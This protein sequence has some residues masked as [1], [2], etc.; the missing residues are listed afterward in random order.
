MKTL[1][2]IYFSLFVASVCFGQNSPQPDSKIEIGPNFEKELFKFQGRIAWIKIPK[3]PAA[4]KPWVWRAHFPDWHTQIDSIL[5]N[6]GFHIAYVNTNDMFGSPAAMQVWDNFYTFLLKNRSFAP[7]VALE[8]VS[9][10]G[11]Y[12]YNWAKRNPMKVSCIY[13]EAPVCDFKSCPLKHGEKSDWEALLKAYKFTHEQALAHTDN[14]I[15]NLKGLAACKVPIMHTVSLEDQIVPNE[16]NSFVLINQYIR[17]GGKATIW[18]MTKGE[19]SLKGH[20]F[21]IENP[22]KIADFIE[23]NSLPV[24]SILPHA[25]YHTFGNFLKNSFL[26]F[27]REKSGRVAFM[28]GS[29]TESGGWRDKVCSFLKEKFPETQFEFINAGI[30]STG[31]TPGA[32]RLDSEVFSKGKIDLLIEE[33]AVNDRTNGFS[34]KAQIRG[35]EGIVRHAL[36]KNSSTD[37]LILHFVDPEKMNDYNQGIIPE[38]IQNHTKVAS[39]YNLGVINLAKEVTDRIRAGE[40]NWKDDF[41]DLHPSPFGQEIYFQSLKTYLNTCY[42]NLDFAANTSASQLPVPL[43][44]F[45][46]FRGRYVPVSNA[47]NLKNWEYIPTWIPA[48]QVATRKQFV[49]IPALV[50][51][52]NG[53]EFSFEFE[54]SAVGICINSGPDAGMLEYSIDG[55]KFNKLDLY[56]QWSSYLH[57]PWYVMLSDELENKKHILNVK[58]SD[59]KNPKS[60]GNAC[61]IVHFLVN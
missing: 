48:D 16:E 13:A 1:L 38:E 26:K 39:H 53:S 20:H 61:R 14:P 31:S 17:L 23:Q 22:E 43:D 6:R 25:E 54:G 50:G 36:L 57:L 29:I 10:G 34:S 58:I 18:P 32:F 33:A 52:K 35:M 27:T 40:F 46:Y 41:K 21:F 60:L 59:H 2:S 56:T 19:K 11:L 30:A 42:E 55:K 49:N 44:K 4:G 15:E 37:I 5:L 3:T 45:S 8:G 7:K 24:A 51:N 9:R 47:R 28:G 12:V